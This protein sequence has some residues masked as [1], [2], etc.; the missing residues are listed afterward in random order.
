LRRAL[1]GAATSAGISTSVEEEARVLDLE[2]DG[3]ASVDTATFALRGGVMGRWAGGLGIKL[4][5]WLG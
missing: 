5:Y 4:K 3:I 1:R 2:L